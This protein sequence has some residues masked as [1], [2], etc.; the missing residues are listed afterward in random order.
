MPDRQSLQPP[1]AVRHLHLWM[2][3][4]NRV[5][6]AAIKLEHARGAAIGAADLTAMCVTD[7]HAAVLL[8]E[9]ESLAE[10]EAPTLPAMALTAPETGREIELIEAAAAGGARLP[11]TRLEREA[12][13][14]AFERAALVIV[15]AP[16]LASAYGRL[17]GYVLDDMTRWRPN[18]ELVLD[19]TRADALPEPERRLRLS[20]HRP[21]L[22]LGLL[23]TTDR[24]VDL[25][26]VLSLGPGV[27]DWLLGAQRTAPFTLSDPALISLESIEPGQAQEPEIERLATGFRSGTVKLAGIWGPAASG[28]ADAVMVTARLAGRP[29]YRCWGPS[30]GRHTADGLAEALAAAAASDAILWLPLDDVLPGD[31]PGNEAAIAQLLAGRDQPVILSGRQAWR[32]LRLLERGGY[33]EL[34]LPAPSFEAQRRNWANCAADLDPVALDRLT[35]RFR[36]GAAERR[37]AVS[38][39]RPRARIAGA[40]NPANSDD[41]LEAACRMVAGRHGGKYALAIEPRRGAGDLVLPRE[42]HAQ[43]LE[44]GAFFARAGRVDDDWGFGR[45]AAG[46]GG[47]KVLFTGD[48]GTGK[49]LA[50]E[51]IAGSLGLQL[52]KA[53]LSQIVSKWVGETEKNL[54]SVF[55]QAEESHAVLFFDEAD[56]LFGKRGEIR[57]G[58]DRYANLEVGYLLQRLETF[59]GLT[60]LASNMRDEID[61]AFTRRFQVTLHFPRPT[62][63][64]RRRLWRLAFSNC[65]A[66]AGDVNLE[67]LVKLDLTGAGIMASARLAGLIAAAR[68]LDT[69]Y[70]S[71]IAEAISRQFRQEARLLRSSDLGGLRLMPAAE[72]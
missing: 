19:L 30:G 72:A 57:H 32:S 69:I 21:L 61:P 12:G 39:A 63:E 51:V 67:A 41:D 68:G 53:D 8:R 14:S 65:T 70:M 46:P 55:Q 40:H 18:V 43:V 22:R 36:F 2:K 27:T 52:L 56:T 66:L 35:G 10:G 20:P 4:L 54:E 26:S 1:L 11:L 33:A 29:L 23:N 7:R 25:R 24:P 50:A 59:T 47:L 48:P 34:T 13:L 17:Y 38:L 60:M 16:E 49:T 9:V 3:A 5:L 6:A 31:E 71:H 15:A 37:A 58:T 28:V 44:I 45:F 62:E 64:E 42:L